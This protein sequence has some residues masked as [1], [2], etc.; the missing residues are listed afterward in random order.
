MQRQIEV[1]FIYNKLKK[2]VYAINSKRFLQS[3]GL[4]KGRYEL[5]HRRAPYAPH[6][7]TFCLS[8]YVT[9]IN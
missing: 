3:L 2:K 8:E 7:G 4:M 1:K 6:D 5:G 9:E